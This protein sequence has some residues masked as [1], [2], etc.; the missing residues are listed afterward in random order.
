MT[1]RAKI[2]LSSVLG[3]VLLGTLATGFWIHARVSS[4]QQ[5]LR[6]QPDQDYR[7]DFSQTEARRVPVEVDDRGFIWPRLEHGWDTAF[8]ELKVAADLLGALYDPY[9]EVSQGKVTFPQFFERRVVGT[10]YVNLSPLASAHLTP[11][12]QVHF[13][14]VRLAWPRQQAHLVIFR[15]HIKHGARVLVVAPHP[16]DAEI[17]AFGL[18]S[19]RNSY[20]VTI[21]AGEAGGDYYEPFPENSRRSHRLKGELRVWDSMTVPYWGGLG[22]GRVCNLGYYDATLSQMY[23]HPER[24]ATSPF[25]LPANMHIF[26]RCDW[27][28]LRQGKRPSPTWKNLVTDLTDV[29]R[30]LRPDVIVTPHPLLDW[31]PDHRYA[32]LALFQAIEEAK[33]SE[34]QLLLYT[35]HDILSEMYPFGKE[36]GLVSL[37]PWFDNG[38][39]FS[40]VYSYQIN[41][42]VQ[43]N[44]YFALDAMHDLRPTTDENEGAM[45]L[46]GLGWDKI[47]ADSLGLEDATSYFRRAVR[48]NELFFV[49][50]VGMTERIAKLS[51]SALR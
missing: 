34:G 4:Y 32:S 37:P 35:N 8:L 43:T 12:E 7:Y 42:D 28:A 39:F 29:L 19:H 1:L 5:L 30:S 23:H 13:K 31:H 18:Y 50:P 27:A 33:L 46:L 49:I 22:E 15:N 14:G 25:A 10:R 9:L 16:D 6:Y 21:T 11:G 47:M 41:Q 17:A 3:L 2:I 36:T 20:I 48:P 40:S 44:K 38:W 51:Q 24:E 45:E 26:R